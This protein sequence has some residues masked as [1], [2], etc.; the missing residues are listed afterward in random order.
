M[1]TPHHPPPASPSPHT[2]GDG[3]RRPSP[4]PRRA[5]LLRP[6]QRWNH[7]GRR[8]GGHEKTTTVCAGLAGKGGRQGEAGRGVRLDT[9]AA[10]NAV[11]VRPAAAAPLRRR[12]K[13]RSAGDGDTAGRRERV[14][15]REGK[16][17]KNALAAERRWGGRA[18]AGLAPAGGGGGAAVAAAAYPLPPP[19][20]SS[21]VYG[22]CG[23]DGG[24][25]LRI[26]PHTARVASVYAG[27]WV[28]T[29]LGRLPWPWPGGM[30]SRRATRGVIA[31]LTKRSGRLRA[32]GG[33]GESGGRAGETLVMG[34]ISGGECP[35]RSAAAPPRWR[36][37]QTRRPYGKRRGQPLSLAGRGGEGVRRG[38]TQ[39]HG[40]ATAAAPTRHHEP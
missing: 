25:G 18:S 8:G 21:P 16:K 17:F 35:T 15:Q 9:G 10:R 24:P 13:G 7:G 40:A 6:R 39:P 38:T 12:G 28:G 31:T 37:D 32:G 19:S 11:I 14:P 3:R 4:F 33:S 20:V 30:A 27:G 22:A 2:T 34:R 26:R 29:R 1:W 36:V 5:A 23:N